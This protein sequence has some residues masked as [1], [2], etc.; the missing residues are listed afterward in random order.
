MKKIYLLVLPFTMTWLSAQD[1]Q[2]YYSGIFFNHKNKAQNFLKV[3]NKNSGVYELTD[4]KGFALIAAKPYDTLVWNNGKSIQVISSYNLYELKYILERQTEKEQVKNKYSKSYDSLVATKNKDAFSI[5][6]APAFLNK[7]SDHYFSKVKKIKQKNDSLYQLKKLSPRHLVFNGSFST[8]FDVISRNAIPDTQKKYVQGRS[9]NGKLTWKGPET[10]EMFSFGPDISTLGFD[11]QPYDY[12]H[13]GRLVGL[14]NAASLA[15]VYDND[16][17]KTTF[18]YSNQLKINAFI[19]EED[20]ERWRLSLELGQQ[21]RQTYFMDQFNDFNFFKAKLKRNIQGYFFNVGFTYE[22]N[23]ATNTNRAGLFNRAYQN[24]LLTPVSFSNSQQIML[25]NGVQRSYSQNADNP[26]FLFSQP[27]TYNYRNSSRQFSF[28][29]TKNWRDF[30]FTVSQSYEDN[31]AWNLDQYKPSS[32][33]FFNGISNERA[34]NNHIYYSNISGSYR[35]NGDYLENVFSA[36]F[37]VNNKESEISSS[38]TG[39]KYLY[40]RTSQDYIFNY[41]LGWTGDDFETG[42]NLGNSFYISNT[43]QTNNYWI[44][45]INGYVK[46]DDIFNWRNINLKLIGAYTQLSSEPEITKSYASYAT[47]LLKAENAYQ[48]FPVNEVESFKGLSN[49]RTKE[50]KAGAGFRLGYKIDLEGEYFN[51][52]LKDDVFPVFEN[53][54]LILKNMA[55]HTYSGYDVNFSISYIRIAQ[56]VF[57]SQRVSF[58]KYKDIVDR[59][60]PGY[61]NLAV[62]GFSDI[63]KTLTEGQVLGSVMGSYFERNEKGQLIIDESGFPKKANGMKVIADPTPDFVMKFN[64]NFSY[65]M[66]SL[67]INWEWKKGGQL[68]NGTKA[69]LDYYGRSQRSADERNTKNYVFQGVNSNGNVNQIPVDFYDPNQN[70][71]Q[72]RWTRYGFLGVAED[73]VEKADYVRINSISLTAKLNIGNFKR[74]LG[75]TLYVNNILL[76]QANKGADPNQNFYDMDNGR[77]LDFFNLPSYKTFG[78]MVSFQF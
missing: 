50:W 30:T 44:P 10:N 9:E 14:S 48:Y 57:S 7:N 41:K 42:V 35:V 45:K 77:G 5:E 58:F 28:D 11:H 60:L 66:L 59:T 16:L 40:Q 27:N 26:D 54:K 51:R 64:H 46:F 21:K 18:S 12:D 76:W 38:L 23:K 6:N 15:N 56:D 49:I 8:S 33:G 43:S 61:N 73:Y 34:Q 75:I 55:D 69:V 37:I 24:A 47:T 17:F 20:V 31:K 36:N 13:N 65:K 3:Y 1:S 39:R 19:R 53:N 74:A 67:D 52:K 29:V 72:N 32:Y 62:S 71:S 25:A 4:E 63:Y 68:W 70:V 2:K 78:C 22:D